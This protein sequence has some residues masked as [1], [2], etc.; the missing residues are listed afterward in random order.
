MKAEDAEAYRQKDK[1][2]AETERRAYM[3]IRKEWRDDGVGQ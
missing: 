1:T 2:N 3:H